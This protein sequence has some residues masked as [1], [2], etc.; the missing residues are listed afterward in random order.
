MADDAVSLNTGNIFQ[1]NSENGIWAVCCHGWAE[2]SVVTGSS[3]AGEDAAWLC[4]G[5]GWLLPDC[6]SCWTAETLQP[7]S[8]TSTKPRGCWRNWAPNCSFADL[9]ARSESSALHVLHRDTCWG[10]CWV[11][12]TVSVLGGACCHEFHAVLIKPHTSLIKLQ[13]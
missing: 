9:G 10:F 4:S 3:I 1:F 6:S 12:P 8:C 7:E 2:G 13:S 11:L 5:R